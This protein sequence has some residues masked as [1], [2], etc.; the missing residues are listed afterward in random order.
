MSKKALFLSITLLCM[1][2]G[3]FAGGSADKNAVRVKDPTSWKEEVDLGDKSPGI[4]NFYIKAGDFGGNVKVSGPYNMY[5]DP[6]SDLPVIGITNPRE[7]MRVPGNLNI[8]GTCV[9]D[10]GVASV[11]LVFDGNKEEPATATG[12]DF[13]SYYLD[14]TKISEGQHTVSVTG[15]DVNGLRGRT[16]TVMWNLDRKKPKAGVE[17]Y[18]LGALVAGKISLAGTVSDGNGIEALWYS[19]DQG[20]TFTP[21]LIQKNKKDPS[22]S[23]FKVE[24]DTT[25]MKDGPV[26][27][28]F[29]AKDGQ[30][31]TGFYTF[32]IYVDNTKPEV[33]ILYPDETKPV[34][35]KF[36][37]SG[38]AG[39]SV[40]IASLSWRLGKET[41]AFD[42]T[43]GNPWWSR[44][45]DV[46]GIQG[47][48]AELEIT[49]KDTSGNVTSVLRKLV[50]DPESDRPVVMLASPAVPPAPEKGKSVSAVSV[51]ES[52]NSIHISGMARDDDGI[53]S[54]YYSIDNGAP[55]EYSTD[56][57]F[58]A[59]AENLANG[60]H[61]V[62]VWARDIN[63][64]DGPRVTV[65]G[66]VCA[67]A[68]PAISVESVSAGS[69]PKTATTA[70]FA[71]GIEIHP[72]SGS[73]LM[74]SITSGS[75]LE[76]VVWQ[77]DGCSEA[78]SPMKKAGLTGGKETVPIP[79]PADVP[80]GPVGLTI[81]AKDIQGRETAYRT[82]VKITDLS[83]ARGDPLV[84]FSDNRIGSDGTV[85][86][87]VNS[88]LSG[89]LVGANV[90]K[91]KL[92]PASKIASLSIEGNALVIRPTGIP[93]TEAR[94]TV[95]V[96]TDRRQTYRS[97]S[98]NLESP[99]SVMDLAIADPGL[100][101][102][103][104]DVT[105]EGTVKGD[106]PVTTAEWRLIVPGGTKAGSA[107]GSIAVDAKT[108]AFRVT[109]A[110]DLIPAGA[111]VVEIV[112]GNA[113]I[114]R[115]AAVPVS[116]PFP[117]FAADPKTGT[118]PAAPT[119]SFFE[120]EFL[121]YF[122]NAQAA[123]NSTSVLVDTTAL[124]EGSY[125]AV[126]IV[127]SDALSVGAHSITVKTMDEGKRIG[128]G[129]YKYTIAAKPA[130]VRLSSAAGNPWACGVY[131]P[132]PRSAAKDA[133]AVTLV[134][135]VESATPVLSADWTIGSAKGLKGTVKNVSGTTWETSVAIPAG[136]AADRTPVS[137][138]V[139]VKD[140]ATATAA[141]E[142]VIVRPASADRVISNEN[143]SWIG[144]DKRDDGVIRL[145]RD[146]SL[147]GVYVGR[148]LASSVIE[149]ILAAPAA[150]DPKKGKAAAPVAALPV[151]LSCGIE[152]G[153]VVIRPT[154]EGQY[155]GIKLTLTDTEGWAYKT[156]A[157]NFLVDYDA[158]AVS[159]SEP[160]SGLWVQNSVKLKADIQEQNKIASVEYTTDFGA[161]WNPVEYTKTGVDK[162]IDLGSVPEGLI[163]I[164]L[165]VTDESGK[166]TGTMTAIRKDTTPPEMS[167]IVPA[168]GEKVNGEIL[169]GVAVLDDG[170][171]VKAEYQKETPPAPVVPAASAKDAAKD[172]NAKAT[173]AKTA[174]APAPAP[175]EWISLEAGSF[176]SF[177]A[178]TA[179]KPLQGAMKLR[180]TDAAGNVTVRDAWPFVIDQEMDLPV[181]EIHLPEDNEVVTQ[182]FVVS[183]VVYD[184]DRPAKV[185]Y[186]I[187]NNPEVE[188]ASANGYSIPVSLSSLTDNEHSVTVYAEDVYGVKGNPVTRN[189][190]VSLEEPK[191]QVLKPSFD[192]TNRGIVEISGTASDKN[193]IDRI[194]VSIDNGNT[195]N[196]ATGTESWKYSFDTK[197]VQDGT[198]VVFV[199]VWDKYGIEGL[200][201]SLINVDNAAPVISVELPLDGART[202][203][204][205]FVSGQT[206]DA[207]H[208]AK[209]TVS[210]RSLGGA[211][212]PKELASMDVTPEA[213][214]SKA[215]DLSGLADG[216][217]NI[218]VTGEDAAGNLSRISR[219]VTVDK[220]VERNRVETLYPLN[221]QHLQGT[222]NVYG[223][224]FATDT[225][226][227]V[228]LYIDGN[229]VETSKITSTGYYGFV[230]SGEK[231]SD[232]SHVI[233]VRSEA[234]GHGTVSAKDTSIVYQSAG[235][236][237]SIDN[238]VMGDFAFER[239]WLE[240][241]AGYVLS[242]S[243]NAVLANKKSP[244]E[245]LDAVKA[246]R[247][248]AISI[249]FDNGRTFRP[250]ESSGG[251]WKFRVET[252]DLSEGYHFLLVR[253]AMED[254]SAAINRTIIQIDKT[255]PV[256]R[257]ISP[258]EGG[259]YNQSL[260]FSGLSSDDTGL[261]Y[262]EYALRKGDKASYEVP[263]FIQGLYFDAH[264]WGATLFDVGAGLTFFDDNVKLQAQYGQ[265]TKEQFAMFSPGP[266]RFGGTVLGAKLLAN[267]LYLPASY[268]FG[269]DWTWLSAGFAL[270]ANF[271]YFSESQSGKPQAI[272]AV[273]AQL[274][275]PRFSF[276]GRSMF[277]TFSAYTEFQLWF[278]PTDVS[279]KEI[280]VETIV[281]RI[282]GGIRMNVF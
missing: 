157:S 266:M 166:S 242:E 260:E 70:P 49:A 250:V 153:L 185:W 251:K 11:E 71:A 9:D 120:G 126:G 231:L 163:G 175:L 278:I 145:G 230:L 61:T 91:A 4:Y 80:Y 5:I 83:R 137:V 188:L 247:V 146:G 95:V 254:G 225:M 39:D 174:A 156:E 8:V 223:E 74:T 216:L 139:S 277:R 202:V 141:S 164:G 135:T 176:V 239:P 57:I 132:L 167:V 226:E 220:K 64:I 24:V 22:S 256:I 276:S 192:T 34:N 106:L 143:F 218:D 87:D 96:E 265:F 198:H 279:S 272:S 197:I 275:F 65:S 63:G 130:K 184:D 187:D 232:G 159:M 41:G 128:S 86:L 214:L 191:A 186:K 134:A 180:L 234:A 160:A 196:D 37:V 161:S 93:G 149:P 206:T 170:K 152:N 261:A 7:D 245:D 12:K 269:P 271:S 203:G 84:V 13:W 204:P 148:P 169:V 26:V 270:G 53:A 90:A 88:P 151:G 274:E 221:G 195:F 268:F 116:R 131:V 42:L 208:L 21:V 259:R 69:D 17:N 81:R 105:V 14:T 136:L 183:G 112:A 82:I 150:A 217:Y 18:T 133:P 224:V 56:G 193:G 122:V 15:V 258:G 158:P 125:P 92:E 35:G 47:K 72:E 144:A 25:K 123:L 262:A 51:V 263:G 244:R 44:T 33:K 190:R 213:I 281:P 118:K 219:N 20:T 282:S 31:S 2:V 205:L 255:A 46:S 227:T 177:M 43:L 113:S 111:S 19:G 173:A 3:A 253:A 73:R 62:S 212:V 210:V 10:D 59:V 229:A 67:G 77:F 222:F 147:S 194:Q 103:E 36:T 257:L 181:T 252:Q 243:D 38:Y 100:R 235:P 76:S 119:V 85:M 162:M 108:G 30:G 52:G 241:K 211:A 273:L 207:V 165:R 199:K 1:S 75:A 155:N 101:E 189:F 40:E 200:Y 280:S 60:S 124:A 121:Y 236:W 246:K 248:S 249:S 28:W 267:V 127:N 16:K 178:G 168:T 215:I 6:E 114:V 228:T 109:V 97:Q 154:A 23:A 104:G 78:S 98:F 209:V 110:A 264:V 68:V 201:S 182:D 115:H 54:I 171:I 240:G 117:P 107:N 45:F 233:S 142:C 58:R 89:Y 94:V 138:T 172:K 66:V 48:M 179:E 55:V 29:K 50:L 79:I 99:G 102:A 238:M 27:C 237:V 32:L 140:G 129:V